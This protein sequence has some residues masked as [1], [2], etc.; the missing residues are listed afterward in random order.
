MQRAAAAKTP[1]LV[2][3][4]WLW[5]QITNK[6]PGLAVVDGAWHMPHTKRSARDEHAEKHLPGAVFF[7]I[8]DCCD[9]SSP[10]GHMLPSADRFASYVG[11]L[12]IDNS[13]HVVIYDNNEQLGLFSAQRVWWT[14]RVFGHSLVSV[15]DGGLAKWIT[16]GY[17]TTKD[18]SAVEA[19]RFNATYQKHAV[20]SFDD[21]QENFNSRQFQ[22]LDAR[23]SGR[24]NGTAP[25]PRQGTCHS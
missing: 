23:S 10:Y 1:G 9:K 24:F 21:I 13:T 6:T 20:K 16:D 14:F 8:D 15:L 12:G 5:T 11:N 7:D 3:T 18:V 17:D 25:E 4:K 2:T 19:K 22:V